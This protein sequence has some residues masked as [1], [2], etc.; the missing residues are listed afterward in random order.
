MIRYYPLSI[1]Q[2]SKGYIKQFYSD[3]ENDRK[4]EI[5]KIKFDIKNS[6]KGLANIKFIT[7]INRRGNRRYGDRLTMVKI[8]LR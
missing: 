7:K 1:Y 4:K 2:R 5:N 6:S 8:S 3:N